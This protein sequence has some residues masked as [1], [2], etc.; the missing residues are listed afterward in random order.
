MYP[1]PVYKGGLTIYKVSPGKTSTSKVLVSCS[2]S[3]LTS[4]CTS[5]AAFVVYYI[6]TH[7]ISLPYKCT[8]NQFTVQVYTKKSFLQVYTTP[9]YQVY[10]N[11]VQCTSV[12]KTSNL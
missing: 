11:P 5:R 4:F 1:S 7:K 8:Q 3:M 9:V 10:T 6:S 2:D 12:Y